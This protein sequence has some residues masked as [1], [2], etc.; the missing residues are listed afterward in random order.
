MAGG[1]ERM[2]VVGAI[3]AGGEGRRF[4]GPKAL[5]PCLGAPMCAHVARALD[6]PALAVI[7]DDAAAAALGALALADPEEVSRGPLRGVLAALR[8]A[9]DM[10]ADWLAVAACDAP[11][12]PRGFAH[13]LI[14]Q[15]QARGAPAAMARAGDRAYPLCSVWR[16]DLVDALAA[17]LRQEKHPRAR[18]LVKTLGGVEVVFADAV[19]FLNVNT[20]EELAR[21]E[22]LLKAAGR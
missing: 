13:E 16:A 18:D 21:A 3:L 22:L 12:L 2:S 20:P 17:A 9:R 11:L 6:C 8:W 14:S 19:R 5:A 1:M 7:G 15:A 10:K 4:G